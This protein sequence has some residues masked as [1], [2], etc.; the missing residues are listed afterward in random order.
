LG[1]SKARKIR[2]LQRNIEYKRKQEI[3][4]EERLKQQIQVAKDY[5]RS[6][7]KLARRTERYP[8]TEKVLTGNSDA[9]KSLFDGE[10]ELE[11][12]PLDYPEGLVL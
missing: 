2:D 4:K 5:V 8:L 11:I 10:S 12:N 1:K 6:H 9:L 7:S 3:E